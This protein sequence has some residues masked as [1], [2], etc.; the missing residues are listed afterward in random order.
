M[1]SPLLAVEDAGRGEPL[2]LLHGLATTSVI[3]DAVLPALSANRR[4]LTVDLPGFGGSEPVGPGFELQAVATRIARGLAAR[5]VKGPFDV[6]GHSL[7]AGVAVA[8]SATRPRAVRRLV[9]VAPAGLA[10]L[11]AAGIMLM[12]AS[13]DRL[14]AARRRL[15]PLA[16]L[17]WGRR[18]LLA[19]AAADGARIPPTHA[20][21]MVEASARAQRTAEALSELGRTDLRPALARSGVPLGLIWGAQDLTVPVSLVRAVKEVRPDAEVVIIERAGHVVMVERPVEFAAALDGLLNRL[22]NGH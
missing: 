8:L 4:V 3:W 9:L 5:G 10:R 19:F 7:G 2:V 12:S 20:R 6:V 13:A 14:L 1:S 21:L 16:D 11:P 17:P 22:P 18:L 15:A